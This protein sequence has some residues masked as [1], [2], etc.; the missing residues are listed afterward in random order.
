[1]RRATTT[2]AEPNRRAAGRRE[3]R[4]HIDALQCRLHLACVHALVPL[5][6][7]ARLQRRLRVLRARLTDVS[8]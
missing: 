8:G 1:M 2:R 4:A 7:A 3:V 5:A 6:E